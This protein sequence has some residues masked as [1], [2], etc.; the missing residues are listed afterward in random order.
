MTAKKIPVKKRNPSTNKNSR[1]QKR[2]HAPPKKVVKKTSV[3]K[4]LSRLL[5]LLSAAVFIFIG[6]IAYAVTSCS[7]QACSN[8]KVSIS[9]M[10]TSLG[11][12]GDSNRTMISKSD[13]LGFGGGHT[14]P[15]LQDVKSLS[16]INDAHRYI[17]KGY[18][19]SYTDVDWWTVQPVASWNSTNIDSATAETNRDIV[20]YDIKGKS[21]N[22]T[23]LG[24]ERIPLDER[25][26]LASQDEVQKCIDRGAQTRTLRV[27]HQNNLVNGAG[28]IIAA[29]G[30]NCALELLREG[31]ARL[32]SSDEGDAPS[33]TYGIY[34]MRHD[35]A[36]AHTKGLYA[37]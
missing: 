15:P 33:Y 18:A 34:Q 31:N 7:H 1:V 27:Y 6:T 29:N 37:F 11:S 8:I 14:L 17:D 30:Q 16:R 32:Q 12:I 4:T 20:L 13:A 10:L 9:N 22:V 35:N 24:I 25:F 2:T 5:I 23:L 28:V 19:S 36:K 21:Y 3:V 26:G